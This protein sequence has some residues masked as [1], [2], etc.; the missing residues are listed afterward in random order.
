MPKN[1]V[2]QM[3]VKKERLVHITISLKTILYIIIFFLGIFFF[4]YILEN[5][6]LE[7]FITY[8]RSKNEGYFFTILVSIMLLVFIVACGFVFSY[9]K[10]YIKIGIILII[11][12]L[13]IEGFYDIGIGLRFNRN[14]GLL[15]HETYESNSMQGVKFFILNFTTFWI[16]VFIISLFFASEKE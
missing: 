6:Y 11:L 15:E 9:D 7:I 3:E 16:F 4:W 14:F 13:I 12:W 8:P 5:E 10:A 1:N 2:E